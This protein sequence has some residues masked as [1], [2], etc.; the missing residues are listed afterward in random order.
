MTKYQIPL[1]MFETGK[2]IAKIILGERDFKLMISLFENK[3]VSRD[4]IN[5]HF[6]QGVAIQTVNRRLHKLVGLGLIR[7]TSVIIGRRVISGYSLTPPGLAK[8]KPMLVYEVKTGSRLSEC[9]LHD[10]ALNDIRKAFE[11]K[12]AVQNYYTENVLQ[13]SIDL[14]G[15]AKFRP[16]IELNS[17]ARAEVD[18]RIGILNLAIEFDSACKSKSRYMHKLN[19]YYG[20]RGIDGVLYICASRHILNTLLKVDKEVADRHRRKPKVYLAVLG[21]VIGDHDEMTFTNAIR[22]IFRVR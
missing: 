22:Y 2:N 7:R 13:T 18:T 20:K 12:P 9:P 3:I 4:Q 15:D 10:I 17:D 16:F 1:S 14:Q 21:D 5:T 8:I 19:A 6:F 11:S